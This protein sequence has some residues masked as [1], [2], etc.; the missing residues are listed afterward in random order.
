MNE[1]RTCHG[2]TIKCGTQVAYVRPASVEVRK[3]PTDGTCVVVQNP[4]LLVA[5]VVT[6]TEKFGGF[7]EADPVIELVLDNRDVVDCENVVATDG[8]FRYA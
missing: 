7:A 3:T 5:R 1:V 8:V 2:Q 6:I 4:R